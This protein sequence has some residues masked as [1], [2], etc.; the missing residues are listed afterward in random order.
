VQNWWSR[1]NSLGNIVGGYNSMFNW[2]MPTD[3]TH[4]QCAFRMRYNITTYDYD[5]WI[6]P[7][8]AESG[9]ITSSNDAVVKNNPERYPAEVPIWEDY[10]MTREEVQASFDSS[11]NGNDEGLK[12]SR[13]YVFKNNPDVDI[14]GELITTTPGELKL[15]MNIN[16]AQFGRTFQDRSHR[17]ALRENSPECEGLPTHNLQVRG[18]RGNIVQTFP[19]VEYDFV[20][21]HLNMQVDE[22]I[23]IQWT[24]SETNPNNNAGQGKQGTDRSNIVQLREPVYDEGQLDTSPVTFGQFG[25]SFPAKIDDLNFLGFSLEDTQALAIHDNYGIGGEMSELD[26]HAGVYFDLGPK[27]VT[28]A[29]IYH[30][31][32]TRNNNFSN[33]SQKGKISVSSKASTTASVGWEGGAVQASS[34]AALIVQEGAFSESNNVALVTDKLDH[35]VHDAAVKSDFVEVYL[36]TVVEF[37]IEIPFHYTYSLFSFVVKHHDDPDMRE[38]SEPGWT[39]QKDAVFDNQLQ[40]ATVVAEKTGVYVVVVG[41]LSLAGCAIFAAMIVVCLGVTLCLVKDYYPEQ[42]SWVPNPPAFLTSTENYKRFN[43]K[44]MEKG[45]PPPPPSKPGNRPPPPARPLVRK[46]LRRPTHTPP[47]PPVNV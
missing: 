33:R 44:D 13:E 4:E 34:G 40:M 12:A 32:C 39:K 37:T 35:E 41:P 22:C 14:F 46:A 28:Q 26:D 17:F 25:A 30:Y 29:G 38:L 21:E 36:D 5:G 24:G 42:L 23:H 6:D 2:T 10:G 45:G 16:T 15:Q 20:P 8:S 18:K 9:N 3:F 11:T 47:A 43:A 27:P 7:Y 19:G 1:D 31:L